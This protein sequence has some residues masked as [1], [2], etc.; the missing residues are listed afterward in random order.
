MHRSLRGSLRGSGWGLRAGAWTGAGVVAAAGPAYPGGVPIVLRYTL[1]RLSLL[2]AVGLVVYAVGARDLLLWLVLT[3]VVSVLLSYVLLRGPRE[4]MT[5]ALL[6]RQQ[7]R[8]QGGGGS[9]RVSRV[10]RDAAAEDAAD[11]ARRDEGPRR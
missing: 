11:D 3:A 7:Q 2:A 4:Q 8:R 1:L 9:G 5:Q 10:D 6:E